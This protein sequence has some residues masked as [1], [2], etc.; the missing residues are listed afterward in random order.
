MQHI[1]NSIFAA[2]CA[3][4]SFAQVR[5]VGTVQNNEGQPLAF[6]NV[7]LL[8]NDMRTTTDANGVSCPD[9]QHLH[10][11]LTRLEVDERY[12]PCNNAVECAGGKCCAYVDPNQASCC[13][14]CPC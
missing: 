4:H 1:V 9:C 5:L 14:D 7:R 13:A 12:I 6:A 10:A 3:L 2:L 11:C 8:G